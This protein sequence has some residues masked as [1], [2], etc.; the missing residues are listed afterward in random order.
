MFR[1]T[2]ALSIITRQLSCISFLPHDAY[3]SILVVCSSTPNPLSLP[4]KFELTSI[5]LGSCICIIT[6][7]ILFPMSSRCPYS[8][9]L[10]PPFMHTQYFQLFKSSHVVS[11]LYIHLRPRNRT[12]SHSLMRLFVQQ[13]QGSP[14]LSLCTTN[15]KGYTIGRRR[16]Y[17]VD[18]RLG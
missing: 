5:R 15:S 2:F 16:F 17:K 9:L 3:A 10:H 6:P 1:C 13:C 18:Q 11:A 14:S 12:N 4:I 8:S 7:Y